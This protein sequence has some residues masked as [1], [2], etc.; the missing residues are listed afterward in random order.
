MTEGS[1]GFQGEASE[2]EMTSFSIQVHGPPLNLIH[3]LLGSVL[4]IPPYRS[5]PSPL[6]LVPPSCPIH[7]L[8]GAP[9]CSPN[10]PSVFP[11]WSLCTC[12]SLHLECSSLHFSREPLGL[13]SGRSLHHQLL[14]RR[15]MLP[16]LAACHTE[17]FLNVLCP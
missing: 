7:E 16:I 12:H 6:F 4:A 10:T 8:H 13:T 9:F 15:P 3:R 1:P 5:R 14:E 2:R 17:Q 11:A